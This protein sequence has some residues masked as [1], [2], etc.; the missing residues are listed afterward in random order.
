[1]KDNALYTDIVKWLRNESILEA[2]DHSPND[3]RVARLTE[4]ADVIT[5][6]R[7]GVT[8]LEAELSDRSWSGSVDRQGGSFDSSDTGRDG[9][10]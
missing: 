10:I 2:V 9:W 8:R 3:E 7:Y 1:M 4:A 6:L 5:Q